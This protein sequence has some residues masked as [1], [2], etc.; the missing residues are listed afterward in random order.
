MIKIN[1]LFIVLL[2]VTLSVSFSVEKDIE[3]TEKISS[4]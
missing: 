2:V 1:R 4:L 3:N